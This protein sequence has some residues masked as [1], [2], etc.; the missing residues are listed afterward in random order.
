[1][2]SIMPEITNQITITDSEELQ[3]FFVDHVKINEEIQSILANHDFA[4]PFDVNAY[5]DEIVSLIKSGMT[6]T[7]SIYFVLS[8]QGY[9]LF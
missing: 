6:I 8:K 3:V 2:G 5:Y 7:D 4:E 9:L 1:M